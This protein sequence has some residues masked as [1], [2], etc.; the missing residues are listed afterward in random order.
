MLINF[1]LFLKGSRNA[2]D[3]WLSY[4]TQH[5]HI[6]SINQFQLGNS[7]IKPPVDKDLKLFFIIYGSLC[8]SN[9]LFTL[10][11]A[12][13]FAYSCILAG[14]YIHGTLINNLLT[15]KVR[16][17]DITPKGRILNRV[18]SDMYAIDDSLPFVLNIFLACL[19]ALVGILALTCYSLP[20]F[21]LSLIPLTIIYYTIQN[22]YRWTSRELK[23]LTSVSLSPVY[24]HFNE[25]LNG[26][27]TIRAFR[28]I[29]KF[30]RKNENYL[31]NYIRANYVGMA[32]SQWLNFRLQ[33]IG[34]LMIT[35]VGFTG[36]LQ[37]LYGTNANASLIGL[38][39]SY[40]LSVTGL[41]NGLI[42]TLTET[43][44][45]MVSVE[46]THQFTNIESENWNGT[47]KA[48]QNWP[49]NPTIVFQNVCLNYQPEA[50]NALDN[51]SF[52]V[53]SGEKIGIVGRTGSGKSSLFMAL[54]RAFELNS[55]SISI[56]D[57]NI[58]LLDLTQL[59]EKISIIPQDPFLFSGTLRENLDPYNKR[60]DL[61]IWSALE[62]CR[63]HEKITNL[64]KGLDLE[65]EERGRNFSTGE[66]QLVCLARAILSQT[67]I[68]CIDEA[69]AS[70][71]FETDSFIQTTIRNEF[72][73]TTVLTI[74]HR[75]NTIFDYDKVIVMNNARIVEFDTVDKLMS[76]KSSTFY[77][78]VDSERQQ[79]KKIKKKKI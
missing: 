59:R 47:L 17:F 61:D 26:L 76:N 70:V 63:L 15:A 5:H 4:W 37:H 71:D 14:R 36:V 2:T 56:D 44:K 21:T 43:E 50:P 28:E 22:Y 12:F 62:K 77:A 16:F 69:T 78:L 20:W 79:E 38:A 51:L 13:S 35:I 55:G 24:T 27:V 18:S 52:R 48:P 32:T 58:R 8:F 60:S 57:V 74:A 65:V 19:I 3:W 34:V 1:I 40:I 7:T 10:V 11:R 67:K 46:R 29:A 72:K 25:T 31:C 30:M 42:N 23:R 45:E 39:L 49:T 75:I 54:F 66:K 64:N 73:T 41:L 9:S 6:S 53:E 33:M 68:L